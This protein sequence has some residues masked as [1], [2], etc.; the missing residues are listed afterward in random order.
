MRMQVRRAH[1]CL[2]ALGLVV[3]IAIPPA[4]LHASQPAD[5]VCVVL[6]AH[7]ASAHQLEAADASVDAHGEHCFVCHWSQSLRQMRQ[8][9]TLVGA[10][11]A[12]RRVSP[13]SGR[14]GAIATPVARHAGRAPPSDS[15]A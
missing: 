2:L 11:P 15:G 13:L 1:E 6:V 14:R 7:D 8:A 10:P 12:A 5:D 4:S 3:T 9:E